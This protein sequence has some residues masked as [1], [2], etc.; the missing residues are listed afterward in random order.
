[1]V[2]KTSTFCIITYKIV[3]FAWDKLQTIRHRCV[4][5]NGQLDPGLP[6]RP[7]ALTDRLFVHKHT[8]IIAQ[9]WNLENMYW[10]KMSE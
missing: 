9:F 3:G 2:Y 8:I 6:E 1:M 10:T 4:L 7:N 5:S